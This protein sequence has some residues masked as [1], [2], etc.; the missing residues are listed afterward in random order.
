V[1]YLQLMHGKDHPELRLPNTL[2]ALDELRRL[3]SSAKRNTR[4]FVP[5]ICS[6]GI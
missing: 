3:Q 5:P 2:E 1:Q 4:S 6:F